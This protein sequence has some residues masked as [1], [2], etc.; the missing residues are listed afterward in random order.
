MILFRGFDMQSRET[1]FASNWVFRALLIG[2]I[3]VLG[4][5]QLKAQPAKDPNVQQP[6]DRNKLETKYNKDLASIIKDLTNNKA[7]PK[8][9]AEAV[10]VLAQWHTF[11]VTWNDMQSTPGVMTRIIN[12]FDTFLDDANKNKATALLEAFTSRAVEHLK[13]VLQN[14]RQIAREN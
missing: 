3:G 6:V 7:T 8:E 4:G 1:S 5:G 12:E 2:L 13:L 11:R 14:D 10:D 9:N